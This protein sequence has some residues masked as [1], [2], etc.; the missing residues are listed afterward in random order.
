MSSADSA[1]FTWLNTHS[2]SLI[3][4]TAANAQHDP[5]C[6][7]FRIC[8]IVSHCGHCC[9]ESNVAGV[10]ASSAAVNSCDR[11]VYARR[12]SM[13]TPSSFRASSFGS[14]VISLCSARHSDCARFTFLITVSL[15]ASS[16]AS[17]QPATIARTIAAPFIL[18]LKKTNAKKKEERRKRKKKEEK[19]SRRFVFV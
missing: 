7:W 17:A 18:V 5:Q 10:A 6:F 3:A 13:S 2:R 15:T 4:S 16:C 1:T 11:H 9:R 19:C 14:R 12:P 8:R